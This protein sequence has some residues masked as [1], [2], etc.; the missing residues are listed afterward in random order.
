LATWV[1]FRGVNTENVVVTAPTPKDT[2]RMIE[3]TEDSE[4][5]TVENKTPGSKGVDRLIMALKKTKKVN[6]T[7]P[8]FS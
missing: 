1:K 6:L 5:K 7:I 2:D 4:G 8:A 3:S